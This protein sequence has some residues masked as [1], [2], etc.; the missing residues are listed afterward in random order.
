MGWEDLMWNVENTDT[1]V[2]FFA[3]IC[4]PVVLGLAQEMM[5]AP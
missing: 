4:G 3:G 5:E 1:S 2:G